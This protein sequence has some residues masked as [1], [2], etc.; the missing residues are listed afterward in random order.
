MIRFTLVLLV[1]SATVS[2][3]QTPSLQETAELDSGDGV[4]KV[5]VSAEAARNLRKA[6]A[7][8]ST[9][10]ESKKTPF[11]ETLMGSLSYGDF[12]NLV[13]EKLFQLMYIA[14]VDRYSKECLSLIRK[15]QTVR[16]NEWASL[17]VGEKYSKRYEQYSIEEANTRGTV[18]RS[19]NSHRYSTF[20]SHLGEHFKSGCQSENVVRTYENLFRR[21]YNYI[22]LDLMDSVYLM[23]GP[24]ESPDKLFMVNE[25]YINLL[26]AGSKNDDGSY[27]VEGRTVRESPESPGY[28][29]RPNGD[30]VISGRWY[31]DTQQ[32]Y[33]SER[34]DSSVCQSW[35][36]PLWGPPF[37][38]A[39][40]GLY[41]IPVWKASGNYPAHRP[42]QSVCE[43]RTVNTSNC[44]FVRCKKWSTKTPDSPKAYLVEGEANAK[45]VYETHFYGK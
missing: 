36:E 26:E 21:S 8:S 40:L 45:W 30:L 17:V 14:Y 25:Y 35:T 38:S 16:K 7:G 42:W 6:I 9:Q 44:S 41:P 4:F 5:E 22:A 2:K 1:F 43:V 3:A 33:W 11:S 23:G 10:A 20:L 29:T 19:G 27:N 37:I 39:S 24:I 13:D 31:P 34:R 28:G 32:F 15:P 18:S 12:D